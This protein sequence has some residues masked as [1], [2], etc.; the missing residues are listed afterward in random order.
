MIIDKIK[1]SLAIEKLVNDNGYDLIN[2]D[3]GPNPP[4][5]LCLAVQPQKG[6]ERPLLYIVVSWSSRLSVT[7]DEAKTHKSCG[8]LEQLLNEIKDWLLNRKKNSDNSK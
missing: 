6:D 7:F 5:K 8:N 2:K 4:G 3:R 1:L